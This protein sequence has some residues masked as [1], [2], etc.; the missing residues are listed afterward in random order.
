MIDMILFFVGKVW[1]GEEY[2]VDIEFLL[3]IVEFVVFWKGF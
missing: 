3:E 1:D 2:F